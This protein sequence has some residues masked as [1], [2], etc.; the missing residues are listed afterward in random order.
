MK[1]YKRDDLFLYNVRIKEKIPF[2]KP[3]G[4]LLPGTKLAGTLIFGFPASRTMRKNVCCLDHLAYG[5]LLDQLNLRH[6][7]VR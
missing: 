6:F 4:E 2:C 3:E 5:L 7:S 1:R